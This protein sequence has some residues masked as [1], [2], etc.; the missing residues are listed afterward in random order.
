MSQ[1]TL[2]TIANVTWLWGDRFFLETN[3][4]NYIWSDPDY[5]GTNE[6]RRVHMTLKWYLHWI[7]GKCGRDKGTHTIIGLCGPD[8][9]IVPDEE[10]WR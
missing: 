1:L 7:G 5:R 4:G 9:T 8:V 2:A 3:V 10:V 6:I